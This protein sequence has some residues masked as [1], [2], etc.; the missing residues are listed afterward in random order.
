MMLKEVTPMTKMETQRTA[1]WIFGSLSFAFLVAVFWLAPAAIDPVR[2]QI[3]AIFS[4]LLA[5]L[6]GYFLTGAT[7][8]V[9]EGKFSR[10]GKVGLQATGG[11][12]LFVL[13]LLWWRSDRALVKQLGQA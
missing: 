8:L 6:F 10:F 9:G 4:S 12:A 11:A 1:A 13:V 7:R 5:G 3:L 2:Q